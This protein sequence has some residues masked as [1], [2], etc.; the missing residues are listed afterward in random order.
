MKDLKDALGMVL[1]AICVSGLIAAPVA[2]SHNDNDAI[3]KLT[4]GGAEPM[5]ARCAVLASSTPNMCLAYVVGS[6]K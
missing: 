4:E 3:Q 1:V 6:A 2:C 5:A